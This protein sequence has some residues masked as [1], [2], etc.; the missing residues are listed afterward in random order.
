MKK[1]VVRY[2]IQ[3]LKLVSLNQTQQP[4][5]PA[6]IS[7]NESTSDTKK[8]EEATNLFRVQTSQQ[9]EP[10]TPPPQQTTPQQ[11]EPTPTPLQQELR[12]TPPQQE[13]TP[14]PFA[15]RTNTESIDHLFRKL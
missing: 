2:L 13:P 9:Q 12:P 7:R 3:S 8:L 4:T 11:Q 5:S 1:A 6:E 14:T 15:A 10:T